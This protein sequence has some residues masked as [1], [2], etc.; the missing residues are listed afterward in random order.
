VR[1]HGEDDLAFGERLGDEA[2]FVEFEVAQAAVDELGGPLRGAGGEI[3]GLERATFRPR[4]AASRAMPAPLTPPP[5]IARSW[6][7]SALMRG[8]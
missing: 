5:M 8:P 7:S 3:G 1:G 4:P 2:V 6:M